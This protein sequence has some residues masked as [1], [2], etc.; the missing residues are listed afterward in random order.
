MTSPFVEQIADA[1]ISLLDISI[2]NP[3]RFDYLM[4]R[5]ND[6]SR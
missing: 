4:G 1:P 3:C 5:A 2:P 6:Q